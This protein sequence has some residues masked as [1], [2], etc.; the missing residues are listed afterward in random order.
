MI[1]F[2][3]LRNKKILVTGATGLIGKS[4]VKFLYN[5]DARVVA[6]V[7]NKAKF[8]KQF[9]NSTIDCIVSDIKDIVPKNLEL[10]YIIHTAC[11]T[12]SKDF[13]EKPVE[14]ILTSFEGTKR[15]LDLAKCNPLSSM[16]F[17]SS[18]EVYG[19]P[20][21]DVKITEDSPTNINTMEVRSS[22]PECKRLCENLCTSYFS[23][24]NVP[25]KVVRLTQTFG[26]GV[27]FSDARIFAEFARCVINSKDIVL[28][29][30]GDTKRSYL[31]IDDAV[32]AILTALINGKNGEVYNVA[33]EQTYCSILDMAN[34]VSTK[35][36][37]NRIKVRIE[38]VQT[39]E[40]GYAP[41]LHMNLD[42]NKIKKLGWRPSTN[43]VD[44][45]KNMID[46]MKKQM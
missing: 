11:P 30:K 16:V 46:E 33:N 28:K 32:E 43:L 34:L 21:T 45:Y 6:M 2:N 26:P 10:D 25:I 8:D 29:T 22:Y 15:I 7:R 4:L 41:T 31:Y 18:M 5:H 24:Y 23:E 38:E 1:N 12:A 9:E 27:E 37:E 13:V 44:M 14:T 40:D 20:K 42:T 36:A 17:L 39:N 19:Y 35:I 3:E